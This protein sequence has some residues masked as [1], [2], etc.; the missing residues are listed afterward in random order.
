MSYYIL[1]AHLVKAFLYSGS[2]KDTTASFPA[3]R[4]AYQ[5]RNCLPEFIKEFIKFRQ[6]YR[7]RRLLPIIRLPEDQWLDPILGDIRVV[8]KLVETLSMI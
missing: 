3:R 5:C 1:L 7:I 6:R 8:L 2:A 4:Y